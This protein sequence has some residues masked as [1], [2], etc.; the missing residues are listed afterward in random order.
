VYRRISV[1]LIVSLVVLR[2]FRRSVFSIELMWFF[3][4]VSKYYIV[5]DTSSFVIS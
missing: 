4:S 5:S 3:Y 2:C 1:L